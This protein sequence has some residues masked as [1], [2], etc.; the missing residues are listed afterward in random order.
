MALHGLGDLIS[1]HLT[2]YTWGVKGFGFS[3]LHFNDFVFRWDCLVFIQTSSKLCSRLDIVLWKTCLTLTF[4]KLFSTL[5]SPLGELACVGTFALLLSVFVLSAL[6]R[7][8]LNFARSRF[9]LFILYALFKG[10]WMDFI[11]LNVEI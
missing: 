8:R 11:R 10:R 1:L 3:I 2:I 9:E 6:V 5:M 7:K 4:L